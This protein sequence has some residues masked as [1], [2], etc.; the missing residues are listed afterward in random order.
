MNV[1][2]YLQSVMVSKSIAALLFVF[3][4]GRDADRLTL[5]SCTGWVKHI[6]YFPESG[7]YT[8]TL[9]THL[10]KG[11]VEAALLNREKRQL[12]RLSPQCPAGGLDLDAGN[13]YSIRWE[14]SGVTGH[15]ELRWRRQCGAGPK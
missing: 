12:M 13:R 4:P 7:T 8:F 15:C 1:W 2:L 10:S 5:D 9:D 11:T 14:L 3:R 6:G